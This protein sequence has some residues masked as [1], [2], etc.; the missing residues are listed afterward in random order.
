M[1]CPECGS[2]KSRVFEVRLRVKG[3]EKHRRRQCLTCQHHFQTVE[4]VE[5]THVG[6][7]RVN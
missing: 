4:K 1:N 6:R 3:T 7:P 2:D 5:S